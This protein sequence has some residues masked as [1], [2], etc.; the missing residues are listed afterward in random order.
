[1]LLRCVFQRENRHVVIHCI[2]ITV[3]N[4]E[5][6]SYQYCTAKMLTLCIFLMAKAHRYEPLCRVIKGDSTL[7]KT[8]FPAHV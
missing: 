4:T 1:M 3:N 5:K 6:Y 8:D 2:D 7:T